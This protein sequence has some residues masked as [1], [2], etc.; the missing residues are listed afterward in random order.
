M[1]MDLK[2]LVEFSRDEKIHK[3]F[4]N[5]YDGTH[6]NYVGSKER[7]ISSMEENEL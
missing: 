3:K 2:E 7:K 1:N 5:T 4:H 6:K